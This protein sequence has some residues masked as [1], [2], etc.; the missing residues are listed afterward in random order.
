MLS[1]T[2]DTLATNLLAFHADSATCEAL[3]V[4][5]SAL[6]AAR[7]ALVASTLHPIKKLPAVVPIVDCAVNVTP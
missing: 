3:V 5:G 1:F 6:N 7:V 4:D 2:A